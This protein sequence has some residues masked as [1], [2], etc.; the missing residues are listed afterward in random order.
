MRTKQQIVAFREALNF[1]NLKDMGLKEPNLTWKHRHNNT[2]KAGRL[3]RAVANLQWT[4]PF[5]RTILWHLPFLKSDHRTILLNINPSYSKFKGISYKR[6]EKWWC[7]HLGYHD[8]IKLAILE[9]LKFS[10]LSW[11]LYNIATSFINKMHSQG[12]KHPQNMVG[13]ILNIWQSLESLPDDINSNTNIQ[14]QQNLD[15]MLLQNELY[16]QQHWRID[17]LQ[18][19][20]RNTSFFHNRAS[21]RLYQNAITSLQDIGGSGILVIKNQGTPSCNT[22]KLFLH[23]LV[24][25]PN[26]QTLF[27]SPNSLLTKSKFFPLPSL[28]IKSRLQLLN[29]DNGKPQVMTVSLWDSLV[30]IGLLQGMIILV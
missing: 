24:S 29:L 15:D 18:A 7:R 14:L 12:K 21:N 27:N 22:S 26:F 13:R 1:H 25:I 2:N 11:R 19:G 5:P 23:P 16:W 20:D 6:Y 4:Y 28:T 10:P 17:W 8:Q 3:D 30:R 9:N